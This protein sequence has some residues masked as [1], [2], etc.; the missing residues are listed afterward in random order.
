MN[1][2]RC[3]AQASYI[4]D[5][6]AHALVMWFY[7]IPTVILLKVW[8]CWDNYR[9][10][11]GFL[12]PAKF[13]IANRNYD[14]LISGVANFSRYSFQNVHLLQPVDILWKKDVN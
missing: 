4:A 1:F 3:N 8:L 13:A 14:G 2:F 5:D 10:L 7:L 6:S 9:Q 12:G 11:G